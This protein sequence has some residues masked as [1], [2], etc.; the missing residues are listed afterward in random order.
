MRIDVPLAAHLVR[1]ECSQSPCLCVFLSLSVVAVFSAD[2]NRCDAEFTPASPPPD[3]RQDVPK[4]PRANAQ[5]SGGSG[6]LQGEG[7]SR[8]RGRGAIR[9]KKGRTVISSMDEEGI[10]SFSVH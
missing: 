8:E 4:A 3:H 10:I 2:S 6:A 1:I 9:E 7:K 5:I